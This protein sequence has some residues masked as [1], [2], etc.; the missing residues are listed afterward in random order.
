MNFKTNLKRA[1][2]FLLIG[3]CLIVIGLVIYFS[4]KTKIVQVVASPTPSSTSTPTVAL[5]KVIRVIDGD[6]I[7]IEGG[8]KVRYIGID[9]A[10]IY[11]K[12][13]C[14]AQ[15]AK[16]ENEKLVDG[17]NVI[18]EKGV[19][20]T[21][22]YGR[23]LRYVF[24]DNEFVNNELVRRGFAKVET[25]PPDVKYKNEFLESENYAKKNNLGLWLGCQSF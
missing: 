7:Q 2:T 12:V 25:V 24:V 3:V 15:E 5:A 10:E 6:T 23:L 19:S 8:Q 22:K 18:L 17:K 21:D 20:E 11:P 9:T 4:N 1:N 16:D 14:Y 13:E